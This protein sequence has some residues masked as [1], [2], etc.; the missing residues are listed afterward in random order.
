[1]AVR[2][3]GLSALIDGLLTT[4]VVDIVGVDCTAFFDE[5]GADTEGLDALIERHPAARTAAHTS[6]IQ[7]TANFFIIVW[8]RKHRD[9]ATTKQRSKTRRFP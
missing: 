9:F 5:L 1:L 3:D 2:A 6:T 4:G 8:P 7:I